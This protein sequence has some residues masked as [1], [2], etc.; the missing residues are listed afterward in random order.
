M[1][2]INSSLSRKSQEFELLEPD[3]PAEH[4]DEVF[5]SLNDWTQLD[6]AEKTD[7]QHDDMTIGIVVDE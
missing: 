7:P 3:P 6:P 5:I 2:A 4:S 1:S